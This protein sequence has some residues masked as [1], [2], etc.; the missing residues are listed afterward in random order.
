MDTNSQEYHMLS[1][2]V[3]P[4]LSLFFHTWGTG[5]R[6]ATDL[7]KIRVCVSD[8]HLTIQMPAVAAWS[9][10]PEAIERV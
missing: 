9:Y 3:S 1:Y 10:S 8:T 5:C 6:L 7:L 4:I 2:T